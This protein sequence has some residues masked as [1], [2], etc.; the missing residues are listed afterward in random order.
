MTSGSASVSPVSRFL[1]FINFLRLNLFSTEKRRERIRMV[2]VTR[3]LAGSTRWCV[4]VRMCVCVCK[5]L[6]VRVRVYV[7]AC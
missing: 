2:H 1:V 7:H 3:T 5:G 6:C 4:R